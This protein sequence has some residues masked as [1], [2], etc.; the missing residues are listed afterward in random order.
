MQTIY[1][2]LLYMVSA[3]FLLNN[4]QSNYTPCLPPPETNNHLIADNNQTIVALNT[5]H[6]IK[7]NANDYLAWQVLMNAL[8]VGHDLIGYVNGT[9]LCP[10]KSHRF[11]TLETLGSIHHSCYHFLC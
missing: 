4:I 1:I 10:T 7:L 6:A 2:Q 8:L 3:T 9:K 11:F 5:H